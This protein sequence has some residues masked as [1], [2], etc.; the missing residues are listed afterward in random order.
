MDASDL[1]EIDLFRA[2]RNSGARSLLIGRRALVALGL[3]VS[4]FDYD[5]WLHFDDVERFN[6]ALEAYDHFPKHAPAEAR[7][8]GRY[9]IENG[10][11]I[12]V[13]I[14]RSRTSID[15]QV[16]S[17]DDAWARRQTLPFADTELLVPS[18]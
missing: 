16:L 8:R 2:V 9:V 5:F 13:L 12:D 7:A 14:S 17:F 4:T 1:P 11:H 3:P 15:G 10:E 18:L 6:S